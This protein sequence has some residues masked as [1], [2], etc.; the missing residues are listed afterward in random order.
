MD[1][2]TKLIEDPILFTNYTNKRAYSVI[3]HHLNKI[4]IY[5]VEDLI[6]CEESRFSSSS[7]KRYIAYAQILKHAYLGQDL[8]FD[9][10]FKKEY[11]YKNNQLVEWYHPEYNKGLKECANDLIRLGFASAYGGESTN[12]MVSLIEDFLDE[13]KYKDETFSM[14]FLLREC[15]YFYT[16][17]PDIR[18]YY[19]QYIDN[20]KEENNIE[21]TTETIPGILDG[22]KLQLQG[23]LTM[24][25]GIDKQ[26]EAIQ[27][28]IK[29]FNEGEKS[30]GRK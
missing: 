23:L 29:S 14:E 15:H 24:R 10:L 8:V 11:T 3:M 28:Q 1:I 26:I 13:I 20:K 9:I 6:N 16:G 30:H 7:R 21:L 22:L 4:G 12:R 5:T 25:D 27:N 2:K 17:G 18:K 19:L